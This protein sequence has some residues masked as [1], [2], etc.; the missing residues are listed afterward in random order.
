MPFAFGQR[1]L[2]NHGLRNGGIVPILA[3]IAVILLIR[4]WPLIVRWWENRSR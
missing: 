3:I 4:F 2:F 1:L